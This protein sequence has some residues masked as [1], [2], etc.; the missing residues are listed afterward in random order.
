MAGPIPEMRPF[1]L[2]QTLMTAEALKGMKRQAETDKIRDAYLGVQMDNAKQAGVIAQDENKRAQQ[3]HD[4]EIGAFKAKYKFLLA[5]N[6][7][8][9]P[10][11]AGYIKRFAPELI[12]DFDQHYGQGSFERLP[13][14]QLA[15]VLGQIR[16]HAAAQAGIQQ[17]DPP[18]ITQ[19]AGP[20]GST[21]LT[22]G[23]DW[24]VVEA[25]KPDKATAQFRPMRPEEI[26]VAGLPPGTAAQVNDGT[27]QIQVLSKRDASATLSQKDATSAKQKLMTVKL[28]RQQLNE[29]RKRFQGIQGGMSAGPLGQGYLPTEGGKS[30]DA[31][32]D[33][34]RS[35]LTALTRT[36]GVGAMSDYETRLDQAKFPSRQNY[37][38]VTQ[39][40]IDA[41]D[42]QLNLIE[43]GYS[44]L[45]G[46]TQPTEEVQEP[47]LSSLSDEEILRQLSGG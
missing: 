32:V 19:Q 11:P 12:Q 37:E 31:A 24:K 33:Q 42:N 25:P 8:K 46:G 14:E 36:P 10:D 21:I 9:D 17:T 16:S 34:M 35:T 45:L 23:D 3:G 38:S 4:A 26:A 6:A 27:G 40:Q 47:D 44:D 22:R 41:I 39:Q 7:A 30:F 13:P 29:I 28:A 20:N 1:D 15:Q 43:R 2:G 5:E 18:Q